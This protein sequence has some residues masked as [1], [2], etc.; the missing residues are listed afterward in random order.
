MKRAMR[1]SSFGP[2]LMKTR[3]QRP[4]KVARKRKQRWLELSRGSAAP[5]CWEE[6]KGQN[7]GDYGVEGYRRMRLKGESRTGCGLGRSSYRQARGSQGGT[8]KKS[9]AGRA[10]TQGRNGYHMVDGSDRG[11]GRHLDAGKYGEGSSGGD[12]ARHRHADR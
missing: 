9:G 10:F 1:L 2:G 11:R 3:R 8:D 4:R 5:S 7:P 6:V 12:H